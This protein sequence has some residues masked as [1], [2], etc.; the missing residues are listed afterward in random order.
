MPSWFVSPGEGVKAPANGSCGILAA[1]IP[2]SML[3]QQ[4]LS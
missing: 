2:F 4:A 1:F 3:A